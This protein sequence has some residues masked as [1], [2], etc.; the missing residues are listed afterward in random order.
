MFYPQILQIRMVTCNFTILYRPTA[1][2]LRF[3]VESV[4]AEGASP[5]KKESPPSIEKQP[6]PL[7]ADV[8]KSPEVKQT[9]PVTPTRVLAL[10]NET[11]SVI[12]SPK[13]EPV[14]KTPTR[15]EKPDFGLQ[16]VV[17]NNADV[18]QVATFI[19]FNRW[20]TC[21]KCHKVLRLVTL[22]HKL[23]GRKKYLLPL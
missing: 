6:S 14:A 20:I 11:K 8:V 18:R 10:E 5:K 9:A 2:D 12:V 19:V 21:Q 23:D 13:Q 7:T 4:H 16:R 22:E 1:I 17:D 3:Q 15:V